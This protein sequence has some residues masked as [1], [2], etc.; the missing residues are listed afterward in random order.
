ML[1][2]SFT[3]WRG[4][5]LPRR[6]CRPIWRG[7][8]AKGRKTSTAFQSGLASP[9]LPRR[10]GPLVWV[11]AASVGEAM[12]VQSL[13]HC[14]NRHHPTASV[15]MTTGT[16]AAAR[17]IG[18]NCRRTGVTNTCRWMCLVR[19]NNFSTTGGRIWRS[20]RI[21]AVAEP[22]AGDAASRRSDGARE[23]AVI[24]PLGCPLAARGGAG[25]ANAFR[26][27]ALPDARRYA[28]GAI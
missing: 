16:V 14:L 27:R 4:R 18:R 23:R 17:L 25:A 15:L 22:A 13:I 2:G 26:F 8:A 3:A 21:R 19:S 20:G 10:P 7:A 28:D 24:G 11:H 12:S 9:A 6:W 5:W 1:A